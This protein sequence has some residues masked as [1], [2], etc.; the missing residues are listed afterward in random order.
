MEVR[1]LI[2]ILVVVD[3]HRADRS[4]AGRSPFHARTSNTAPDTIAKISTNARNR[5]PPTP[6]WLWSTEA[7]GQVVDKCLQLFGGAGYMNEYPITRMYADA[8]VL[9]ILG[10]S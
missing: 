4:C 5:R 2:A 3:A 10:G 1:I 7:Y 9:C 8:R 6:S